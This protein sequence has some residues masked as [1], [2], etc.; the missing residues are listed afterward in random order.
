MESLPQWIPAGGVTHSLAAECLVQAAVAASDVSDVTPGFQAWPSPSLVEACSA[1]WVHAAR[2]RACEAIVAM[3][4]LRSLWLSRRTGPVLVGCEGGG[5]GRVLRH[6]GALLDGLP[7]A[8]PSLQRTAMHTAVAALSARQHDSRL[9]LQ[10]LEVLARAAAEVARQQ[11][12]QPER[13]QE[14]RGELRHG[15]HPHNMLQGDGVD[16]TPPC[17]LWQAAGAVL[18]LLTSQPDRLQRGVAAV[19]AVALTTQMAPHAAAMTEASRQ[20]EVGGS[21]KEAR[22]DWLDLEGK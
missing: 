22:L 9:P 8:D 12:Q 2:V 7:S 6:L 16:W 11:Q 3:D 20:K 18:E 13:A 1:L 5:G 14:V 15:L 10:A 4:R 19:A 21:V 17:W